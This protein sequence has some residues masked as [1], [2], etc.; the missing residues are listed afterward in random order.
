M[1]EFFVQWD[2]ENSVTLFRETHFERTRCRAWEELHEEK[3]RPN[4]KDSKCTSGKKSIGIASGLL[5][6]AFNW[7]LCGLAIKAIRKSII[8]SM[9]SLIAALTSK[10]ELYSEILISMTKTA[11]LIAHKYHSYHLLC[12]LYNRHYLLSLP[13]HLLPSPSLQVLTYICHHWH[14]HQWL[15]SNLKPCTLLRSVEKTP[16]NLQSRMSVCSTL[17]IQILSHHWLFNLLRT[18]FSF[19]MAL[20]RTILILAIINILPMSKRCLNHGLVFAVVLAHK[21]LNQ[22]HLPCNQQ[23]QTLSIFLPIQAINC[24]MYHLHSET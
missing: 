7:I 15:L 3:C 24:M 10:M 13:L 8:L 14:S 12:L 16:M 19:G 17:L 21:T 23:S 4:K 18:L 22:S 9:M 6:P 20:C 1:K 2:Q 11:D 5:L